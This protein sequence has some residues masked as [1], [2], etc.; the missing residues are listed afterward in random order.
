MIARMRNNNLICLVALVLA[1]SAP[2]GIVKSAFAQAGSA[3]GSVGKQDK[4]VS[5]SEDQEPARKRLL[6]HTPT[7]SPEKSTKAVFGCS[8]VAGSYSYPF[9][10]VTVFKSDG[11]ASNSSGLQA[12]WTCAG[13]RVTVTWSSIGNVD[14][15]VPSG[16]SNFSASNN[17]GRTWL[18][19]RL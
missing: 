19:K 17:H 10:T 18:A 16:G 9:G 15:L 3:G 11:T 13:G 12:T 14:T 2:A 7:H 1:M 4:S 5:G 8:H 6:Q